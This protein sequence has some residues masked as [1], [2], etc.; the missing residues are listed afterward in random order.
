MF[1]DDSARR[2]WACAGIGFGFLLAVLAGCRSDPPR[3]QEAVWRQVQGH[4]RAEALAD[5]VRRMRG[6]WFVDRRATLLENEH[7]P[8]EQLAR[9]DD[10]L[11]A[12]PFELEI[13]DSQ[14][15][16]RSWAQVNADH[17][18]VLSADEARILI[19]LHGPDGR[20]D[21]RVRHVRLTLRNDQLLITPEPWFTCVLT[22]QPGG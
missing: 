14:Y 16:S 9:L 11:R 7:L 4:D 13:T 15:V 19:R 12:F 21:G 6:H 3:V 20:D 18:S 2:R 1:T 8:A 17:Y 10:D 5:P 22:R